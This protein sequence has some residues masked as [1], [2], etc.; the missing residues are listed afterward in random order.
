M[1]HKSSGA[2]LAFLAFVLSAAPVHAG[3]AQQYTGDVGIETDP[4]VIFVD[5]LN[6]SV[7]TIVARYDQVQNQAGMTSVADVP[8]NSPLAMSL[9]MNNPSAASTSLLLKNLLRINPT[10]YTTIFLRVY[11]KFEAGGAWHH[12]GPWILGQATPGGIGDADFT[13]ALCC[14]RPTGADKFHTSVEFL[15]PTGYT[16]WMEMRS[17]TDP[18]CIPDIGSNCY[19]GN[20]FLPG[21]TF[22]TNQWYAIEIGV[23]LN[24]PTTA[25]NGTQQIWIDGVLRVNLSQGSPLGS[26]TDNVWTTGAGST[27][28]D[29]FR[30][31]STALI[32]TN[33]LLNH[34]TDAAGAMRWSHLVVATAPIG[35]ISTSAP[36]R[37]AAPCCLRLTRAPTVNLGVALIGDRLV[38]R[39]RLHASRP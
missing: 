26:W 32:S 18:S 28:F 30:W 27:P 34:F 11:V 6:A 23:T 15:H 21:F 20:T 16:T 3:L 9:R 19:Y 39:H 8:P 33:F 25:R 10:G 4:A 38:P 2:G 24:T 36:L 35:P 17:S 14:F 12:N 1:R 22:N 29:G 31:R 37:P 5:R 7:P 13:P